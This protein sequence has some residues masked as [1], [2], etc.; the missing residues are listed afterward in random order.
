MRNNSKFLFPPK[1]AGVYI[2][3]LIINIVSL[4]RAPRRRNKMAEVIHK[5]STLRYKF[6]V[7]VYLWF[8]SNASYELLM[9][10]IVAVI[11]GY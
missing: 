2:G 9:W 6:P 10:Q 7:S 11:M 5:E 3:L 1:L 4:V 8:S